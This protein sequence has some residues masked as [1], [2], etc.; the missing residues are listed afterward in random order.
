MRVTPDMAEITPSNASL[1]FSGPVC[2]KPV[3][4]TMMIPGLIRFTSS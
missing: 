2:P 1:S 4:E 3:T